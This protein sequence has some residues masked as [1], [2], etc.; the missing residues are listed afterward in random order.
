M[1]KQKYK[2]QMPGG[3]GDE[4]AP[5]DFDQEQLKKGVTVELEHA[6]DP[7][8][9]LE[10]AIDHLTE[11]P[12]YYDLLEKIESRYTE[13]QRRIREHIIKFL[14]EHPN[15]DDSQVHKLAED[16]GLDHDDL[17]EEIYDLL[18]DLL[19]NRGVS[20]KGKDRTRFI[21]GDE[22]RRMLA[23]IVLSLYGRRERE[24]AAS[25]VRLFMRR[26]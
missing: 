13:G 6:E 2:D 11:D 9:A 18:S 21:E 1:P 20:R 19:K 22:Y 17:E 4:K 16:L 15:P 5:L 24:L 23:E 12:Y 14:G 25:A 7:T 10:I 26:R 3:L 8:I